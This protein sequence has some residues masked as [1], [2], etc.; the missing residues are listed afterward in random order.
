MFKHPSHRPFTPIP[1]QLLEAL[2]RV[3]L[4]PNQWKVLLFIVRKT[5]GFHKP[6]DRIP[7][8]QFSKATGLD[9]RHVARALN[10]LS[11]KRVV[12]KSG[13]RQGKIYAVEEDPRK[14]LPPVISRLWGLAL[15]SK[16]YPDYRIT[17]KRTGRA[18]QSQT[19]EAKGHFLTEEGTVITRF[20]YKGPSRRLQF[21]YVG[22]ARVF[23]R[24]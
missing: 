23:L 6:S 21:D 10:G 1:N 9:R 5:Y 17:D 18:F 3:K 2:C 15:K 19:A 24:L 14:W 8:S 11:W 22:P 7:L 16:R 20:S 13:S 12:N 4:S